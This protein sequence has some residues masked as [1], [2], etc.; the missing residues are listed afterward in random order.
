VHIPGR[1]ETILNPLSRGCGMV[2]MFTTTPDA[3]ALPKF[4]AA[5]VA[6]PAPGCRFIDGA[7]GISSKHAVAQLI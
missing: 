3:L 7:N 6:A 5:A 2:D 1:Y 4:I